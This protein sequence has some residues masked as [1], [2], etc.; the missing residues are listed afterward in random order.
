MSTKRKRIWPVVLAVIVALIALAIYLFNWNMLRGPIAQR[1]SDKLGRPF[2]ITG[3]LHVRLGWTPTIT[4]EG[5]TLANAPWSKTPTMATLQKLEFDLPLKPLLHQ[6]IQLPRVVLT[7]P[8]VTLEQNAQ[9]QN[10]WTFDQLTSSPAASKASAPAVKLGQVNVDHGH[11]HYLDAEGS[12]IHAA[13][14]TRNGLQG[15]DAAIDVAAKGAFRKLGFNVSATGGGVLDLRSADQ[16]YPLAASGTVGQTRFSAKGTVTNP[17]KPGVLSLNF[18][19]SGQSLAQLFPILKLPLPATPPYRL[20]GHL[21]H[22]NQVW[23]LQRFN[24]QVGSSDIGGDFAVDLAPKTKMITA[25][26]SSRRVDLADFSGF[27]GARAESGQPAPPKGDR[28]LP[29]NPFSVEKINIANADVKFKGAQIVNASLPLDNVQAHLLLNDGVLKLDPLNLGVAGGHVVATLSLDSTATPLKTAVDAAASRLQLTQL[30][31]ELGKSKEA[32]AGLVG[33]K[34]RLDMQG[35]SVAAM[36]G[37]A[38]GNVA[39]IM[40]GGQISKLL[41]RLTNLDIANLVPILFTGDKPVPVRCMVADLGATHGDATIKTLILDTD[42]QVVTGSGHVNFRDE[43]LDMALKTNPKDISLVAFRGPIEITGTF[44]K[45][46]VRPSL[47]QPVGRAAVAVGLALI[48]PPLALLPLVDIGTAKDTPCGQ[49]MQQA[50][51]HATQT[52]ATA[53]PAAH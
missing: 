49:L 7:A 51:A 27:I 19:L 48:S 35:N 2:A 46:S 21:Q 37:S 42:K 33:G 15:A 23:Q 26:L 36:L 18:N 30:V 31:P 24:G 34:A 41:M 32:S 25:D 44:K 45:P 47:P 14:S 52:P 5:L 29:D 38:N 10:N 3:D 9:G 4:A 6:E 1:V 8:D 22:E 17:Q 11:V 13:V 39:V 50:S 40:D 16:P 53:H 20:A 12:D 43:R 28:I